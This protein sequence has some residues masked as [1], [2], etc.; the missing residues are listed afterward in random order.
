M[1][2]F[3]FKKEFV[4]LIQD[5]MKPGTVRETRKQSFKPGSTCYLFT[6]MR[7]NNCVRI[8]EAPLLYELPIS[9]YENDLQIHGISMWSHV[10]LFALLDGFES[11]EHF[12]HFFRN[13]YGLP[14]HG[15][16]Y[17]WQ[18]NLFLL[19][20]LRCWLA[21]LEFADKWEAVT[22]QDIGII[23]HE[24]NNIMP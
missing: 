11:V 2:A 18:R 15:T 20:F 12:L 21:V 23:K 10:K 1:P 24:S 6:G 16:W 7:T 9:I 19:E 17:V 8:K 3:N 13:Q 14:F 5:G 22:T 4:P